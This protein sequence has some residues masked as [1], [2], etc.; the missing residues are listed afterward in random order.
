MRSGAWKFVGK[1]RGY[2]QNLRSTSQGAKIFSV[3]YA[4][5]PMVDSAPPTNPGG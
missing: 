3:N 2:D 4:E 5:P 1:Q